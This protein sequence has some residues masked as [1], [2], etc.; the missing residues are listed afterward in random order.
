MFFKISY[1]SLRDISNE[2]WPKNSFCLFH[3]KKKNKKKFAIFL[4][5]GRETSK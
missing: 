5:M 3:E 2:A 1:T 4:L